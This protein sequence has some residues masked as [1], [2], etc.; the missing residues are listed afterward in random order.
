MEK[1][2]FPTLNSWWDF[3]KRQIKSITQMYSSKKAR[4]KRIALN[5]INAKIN[6]LESAPDF[7]PEIQEALKDQRK[8]LNSLLKIEAQGALVRSRFKHTAEVDTC[9][10]YFFS[11]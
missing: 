1:I 3:G 9:S 7:T 5:C 2:N 11:T 10:T 4:E 8:L 6:E